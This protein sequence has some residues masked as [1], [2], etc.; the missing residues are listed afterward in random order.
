MSLCISLDKMCRLSRCP[1]KVRNEKIQH[2]PTAWFFRVFEGHQLRSTHLLTI[3]T[4]HIVTCCCLSGVVK[5]YFYI[6]FSYSLALPAFLFLSWAGSG[7]KV[8][9]AL[10]WHCVALQKRTNE[11]QKRRLKNIHIE[12]ADTDVYTESRILKHQCLRP[13]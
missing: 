2:A 12:I 3:S 11:K 5:L 7:P 6:V 8:I 13:L 9:H 4:L 1:S 10:L